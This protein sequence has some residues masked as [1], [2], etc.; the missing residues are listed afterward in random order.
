MDIATAR[1]EGEGFVSVDD[2]RLAHEAFWNSYADDLR[3]RLADPSWQLVDDTSVAV[4]R[5]RLVSRS[6]RW[7]ARL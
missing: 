1:A 5:F 3:T 6:P 4:E 7:T 2:W